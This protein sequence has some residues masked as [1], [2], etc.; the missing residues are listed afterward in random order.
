M[1]DKSVASSADSESE[2][3][4][5][6]SPKFVGSVQIFNYPKATER[7]KPSKKSGKTAILTSSPFK[8]SLCAPTRK[9]SYVNGTIFKDLEDS[10][11]TDSE[12][13]ECIVDLDDS[14]EL[15]SFGEMIE[16]ERNKERKELED[17]MQQDTFK[18]SDRK[19]LEDL[20]Q[21]TFKKGDRMLVRFRRDP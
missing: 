2:E 5:L 1:Y 8:N 19:E 13:E 17:L 20:M 18:K 9:T 10:K 6:A 3:Y 16:T 21:D 7:K 15:E 4:A 14:D 11:S 12:D